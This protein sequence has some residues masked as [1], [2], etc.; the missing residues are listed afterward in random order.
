MCASRDYRSSLLTTLLRYFHTVWPAPAWLTTCHAVLY[1]PLPRAS[2]RRYIL[3]VWCSSWVEFPAAA[4]ANSCMKDSTSSTLVGPSFAPRCSAG[5]TLSLQR[6]GGEVGRHVPTAFCRGAFAQ[7]PGKGAHAKSG[8]ARPGRS[9]GAQP[10]QPAQPT[11]A[12]RRV[13]GPFSRI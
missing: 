5:P 10:A 2:L 8:P 9:H 13:Y 4:A 6:K 3:D 7:R 11:P 1:A 12:A